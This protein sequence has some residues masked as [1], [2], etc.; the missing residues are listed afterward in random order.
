MNECIL[1]PINNI[2]AWR[3]SIKKRKKGKERH[4]QK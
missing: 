3:W 1:Q 2:N 4:I